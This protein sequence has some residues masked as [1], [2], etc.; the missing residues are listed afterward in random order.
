MIS[1]G[2]CKRRFAARFITRREE[3][4][5]AEDKAIGI[6]A[7]VMLLVSELKHYAEVYGKKTVQKAVRVAYAEVFQEGKSDG[8]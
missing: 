6:E 5:M 7:L 3:S 8:K 2:T 1:T 4:N